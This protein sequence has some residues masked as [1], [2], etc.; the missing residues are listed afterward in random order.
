MLVFASVLE[1]LIFCGYGDKKDRVYMSKN[2]CKNNDFGWVC[3][4][5]SA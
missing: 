4:K 1:F 3:E 2:Y 5:I